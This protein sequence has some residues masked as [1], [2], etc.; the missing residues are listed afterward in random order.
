MDSAITIPNKGFDDVFY[1]L[2]SI[3]D[4]ANIFLPDFVR[5]QA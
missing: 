3:K 2:W 1:I 4:I 5:F